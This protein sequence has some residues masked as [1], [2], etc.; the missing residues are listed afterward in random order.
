T[1][2]GYEAGKLS[3]QQPVS[4]FLLQGFWGDITCPAGSD[5]ESCT[6]TA[7]NRETVWLVR[8]GH[9]S[10]GYERWMDQRKGSAGRWAAPVAANTGPTA[11]VVFEGAAP[12]L[13]AVPCQD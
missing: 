1:R 3:G 11:A 7:I 5:V 9:E 13:P 10:Y 8:V 2:E 4:L 6:G 12:L